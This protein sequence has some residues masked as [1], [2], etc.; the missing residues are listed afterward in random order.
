MARDFIVDFT[1]KPGVPGQHFAERLALILIG[2]G[3]TV[4]RADAERYHVWNIGPVPGWRL[5]Q[6][7]SA[8]GGDGRERQSYYIT[9]DGTEEFRNM[10]GLPH[11]L[12]IA[13]KALVPE[14]ERSEGHDRK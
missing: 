7:P 4:V 11:S 6:P 9:Y 3:S 14:V 8:A 2:E 13:I 12:A 5:L 10:P 1:L